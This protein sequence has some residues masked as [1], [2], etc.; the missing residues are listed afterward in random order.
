MITRGCNTTALRVGMVIVIVIV[1]S[2]E[3]CHPIF[4]KKAYFVPKE[5]SNIYTQ[6]F[7][8]D[9]ELKIYFK[10]LQTGMTKISFIVFLSLNFVLSVYSLDCT[11]WLYNSK[12]QEMYD[13]SKGV[14]IDFNTQNGFDGSFEKSAP[15]VDENTRLHFF[16]YFSIKGENCDKCF[17]NGF[18]RRV[19]S[20]IVDQ[21]K[22]TQSVLFS[23]PK[24]CLSKFEIFC[25]RVE[26]EEKEEEVQEGVEI[27]EEE[28]KVEEEASRQEETVIEAE[29]EGKEEGE[30][31]EEREEQDIPLY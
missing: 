10:K 6:L 26:Q 4:K 27:V 5:G 15:F 11:I 18:S 12:P 23:F 25:S 19:P 29:E 30:E 13:D 1:F 8:Q 2:Y 21:I 9:K 3:K 17:L 28:T 7:H 20:T 31:E 14:S 16:N 22:L 24:T